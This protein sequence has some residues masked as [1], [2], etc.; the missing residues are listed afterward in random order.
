MSEDRPYRAAIDRVDLERAARNGFP[1]GLRD[2]A[3]LALVDA[4]VCGTEMSR[5]EARAVRYL[6]TSSET[7]E[8]GVMWRTEGQRHVL[9]RLDRIQGAYVLEYLRQLAAWGTRRPLI[10][11]IHGTGLT[12]ASIYA[13]LRRYTAA[14]AER[15]SS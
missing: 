4:G 8:V 3:I 13:L 12:F 1:L 15:R 2:A 14:A 7:P 9:V 6:T 5:L 11:G 10:Q